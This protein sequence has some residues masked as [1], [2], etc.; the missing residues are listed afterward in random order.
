MEATTV[1]LTSAEGLSA[2]E[3]AFVPTRVA[4][5]MILVCVAASI[6]TVIPPA[7]EPRV[8]IVA[9]SPTRA[10]IIATIPEPRRM[11]PVVPRAYADEDSIYEIV[12]SVI[13]IRRTGV[14]IIVVV[15]VGTSWRPSHIARTDSDSNPNPNL[16]LRVRK[17]HHQNRQQRDIF[18]I[19][20]THLRLPEPA[21]LL[22][23]DP[24]KL[25]KS[26]YLLEQRSGQKVSEIGVVDFN[27]PA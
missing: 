8:G 25:S 22:L 2:M 10:A 11:S 4:T 7:L 12:G 27:H 13:A 1:R 17:W 20:H 16:G 19:T 5:A 9:M 26:F 14:R 18:Q 24:R 15:P 6:T 23:T 3:P 21:S